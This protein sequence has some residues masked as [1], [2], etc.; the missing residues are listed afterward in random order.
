MAGLMT[1]LLRRDSKFPW[2]KPDLKIFESEVAVN[3]SDFG[4]SQCCSENDAHIPTS[5][6]TVKQWRG[7]YRK[8]H[9]RLVIGTGRSDHV[10]DEKNQCGPSGIRD[11]AHE[12]W[13]WQYAINRKEKIP[14][15]WAIACLVIHNAAPSDLEWFKSHFRKLKHAGHQ[16]YHRHVLH[17][18]D[19]PDC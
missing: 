18:G 4:I 15:T 13:K 6:L 9:R 19:V 14:E 11:Y 5:R 16:Q 8:D 12:S 1:E 17:P 2:E 10:W 7:S 3:I